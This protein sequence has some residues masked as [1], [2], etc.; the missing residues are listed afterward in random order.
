MRRCLVLFAREPAR[1]AREKGF[2]SR[3]AED[4]FRGFAEGWLE[5]C[6]SAGARL[7]VAAPREDR[8]AWARALPLAPDVCWIWQRGDSLGS[9]L[10]DAARRGTAMGGRAVLVGGDVIPDP[11][12]LQEAFSALEGGADAAVSPSPDGGVS[13]LALSPED[14]DLLRGIRERRRTIR[15]DLL[16]ALSK[17]GRQVAVLKASAD[18][19]GRRSLRALL[20]RNTVPALLSVLSRLVLRSAPAPSGQRESPPRPRALASPSGLRAPPSPRAA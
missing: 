9:R 6:R 13:L 16:Y 1:Q 4:L 5:A 10:E 18:V 20:R 7:I 15:R 8:F 19:D 14:L 12:A 3:E 17:R 2:G 11:A